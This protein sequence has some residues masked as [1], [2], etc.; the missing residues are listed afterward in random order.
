[1]FGLFK[2]KKHIGNSTPTDFDPYD[3]TGAYHKLLIEKNSG[4]YADIS[5]LPYS[6]EV[7]KAA[8]VSCIK[9]TDVKEDLEYYK[10]AYL[11][12]AFY[13]PLSRSQKTIL[14]KWDYVYAQRVSS[15][16]FTKINS[17]FKKANSVMNYLN[18][19]YSKEVK[20]LSKEL[21]QL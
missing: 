9:A 13:Q 21:E 10:S 16:S 6:K 11:L 14:E 15:R 5:N 4:N 1:M 19:V 2:K 20:L 18:K 7:I 3:V 12:L 17:F 8:L